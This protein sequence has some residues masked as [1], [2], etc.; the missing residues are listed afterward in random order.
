M[1]KQ[2]IGLG[3]VDNDGTGDT[4]K[5]AGDKINDNFDELYGIGPK[6]IDWYYTI[7]RIRIWDDADTGSGYAGQLGEFFTGTGSATAPF[8]GDANTPQGREHRT[9]TTLN[10]AYTVDTGLHYWFR[11]T[12]IQAAWF[13]RLFSTNGGYRIWM[14]FTSTTSANMAASEA[15]AFNF[16]GFRASSANANWFAVTGDGAGTTAV[17]TG[18]AVSTTTMQIMRLEWDRDGASVRFYIDTALVATIATTLPASSTAMRCSTTVTNL[19]GGD[20]QVRS[21]LMNCIKIREGIVTPPI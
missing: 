12:R 13:G 7:D 2:V 18:V 1:A 16:V 10:N 19:N 9:S 17:D 20:G 21:L 14:A 4:L 5:A 6:A 3:T 15:P 8:T 11:K